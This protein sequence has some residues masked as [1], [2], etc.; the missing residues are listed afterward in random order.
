MYLMIKRLVC[1]NGM[2]LPVA[3]HT[4]LRKR[5]TKG[6]ADGLY[7]E[8]QHKT[9]NLTNSINEGL[10]NIED[11]QI[12][13]VNNVESEITEVLKSN[14]LS[15]KLLP[16]IMTAWQ[17]EPLSNRFGVSMAISDENMIVQNSIEP[18]TAE[19]LQRAAGKYLLPN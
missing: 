13:Q 9:S 19:L 14:G 6:I 16:M 8:I 3:Q 2:T 7:E 5:H 17:K 18:E 11:A 15:R 1:S 12:V 4:L 10:K